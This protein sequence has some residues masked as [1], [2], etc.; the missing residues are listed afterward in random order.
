[1]TDISTIVAAAR[2]AAI[3]ASAEI[4]P[5]GFAPRPVVHVID[6]V[7]DQPYVGYVMCRPYYRGQDALN[8]TAHLGIIASV[9]FANRLVVSW[10]EADLRTSISGPSQHHPTGIAV[11]DAALTSHALSWHP[12]AYT[13]KEQQPT[14]AAAHLHVHWGQASYHPNAALPE[15]ISALLASWRTPPPI[16]AADVGQFLSEALDHGYEFDMVKR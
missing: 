7:L 4:L 10:D 13:P 5:L 16:S 1:M 3:V 2:D 12:Y 14:T 15:P 9:M 8:A 6:E 11:L